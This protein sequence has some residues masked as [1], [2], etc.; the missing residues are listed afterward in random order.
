MKMPGALIGA[1]WKMNKTTGQALEF[2]RG[3][4][5]ALV[6]KPVAAAVVIA[7]PF[8][9]LRSLAAELNDS[10]VCLAAQNMHPASQ[11]AFTGE[12]SGEMLA[13]AGCRYCIIGHSERRQLFG[14]GNA[15]INAKITA[16]LNSGLMPIFC[17]GETLAEKNTGETLNVLSKQ[18]KEGLNKIPA[19]DIEK[20]AVAYEP[21]WAIGTGHTAT[22]GQVQEAHSFIRNLLSEIYGQKEAA[23]VSIIYGGSVT[24]VN[25][26]ALMAE[27]E[28]NGVLVGSASLE[29]ASFLAIVNYQ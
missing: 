24:A 18:V 5:A 2:V 4:K 1:N 15:L 12:I 22:P 7:P 14:E 16:A 29:L 8:T 25:I 23:D 3:L 11:G 27:R 13:D 20:I 10:A 21:V 28:I 17:I 6:K 26:S 9:S 19:S